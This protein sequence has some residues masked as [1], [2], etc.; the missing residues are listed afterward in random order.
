[1]VY[2]NFYR[3]VEKFNWKN[4]T[5]FFEITYKYQNLLSEPL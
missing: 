1:M 5:S 3:L 4:F 2:E